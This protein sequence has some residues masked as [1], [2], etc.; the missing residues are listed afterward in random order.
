MLSDLV[1]EDLMV[2]APQQSTQTMDIAVQY[3]VGGLWSVVIWRLE[4]RVTISSDELHAMFERLSLPG[5]DALFGT[6]E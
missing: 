4:R 6:E 5:L 2:K 1:R 3:V